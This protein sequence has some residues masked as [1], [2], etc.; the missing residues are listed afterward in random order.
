[1]S[2]HY[3]TVMTKFVNSV[4]GD[5]NIEEWATKSKVNYEL[6]TQKYIDELANHSCKVGDLQN[7]IHRITS[8]HPK[9]IRPHER[10][11]YNLEQWMRKVSS[12]RWK[13]SH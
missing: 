11:V 1:M 12:E 2:R 6:L 7:T 4:Y 13:A 9:T 10:A 8:T 5:E 3:Q